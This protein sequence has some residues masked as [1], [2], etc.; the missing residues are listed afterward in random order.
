M[1]TSLLFNRLR[2]MFDDLPASE[3]QT[4]QDIMV[5]HNLTDPNCALIDQITNWVYADTD[6]LMSVAE[7]YTTVLNGDLI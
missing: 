1:A 4:L 2:E 7:A 6:F 3:I 5:S